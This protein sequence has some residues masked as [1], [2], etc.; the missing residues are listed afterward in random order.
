M[1][2]T[3]AEWSEFDSDTLAL[4]NTRSEILRAFWDVKADIAELHNLSLIL[5]ETLDIIQSCGTPDDTTKSLIEQALRQF[6]QV[7][8][9]C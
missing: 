9:Q 6:E 8:N 7:I 3:P 5:R 4:T 2:K 1:K